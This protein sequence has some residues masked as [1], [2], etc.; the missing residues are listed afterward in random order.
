MNL[1][2]AASSHDEGR[3]CTEERE[4]RRRPVA[5][6]VCGVGDEWVACQHNHGQSTKRWRAAFGLVELS[7][8]IL[9]PR[10]HRGWVRRRAPRPFPQLK[11]EL[12][13]S[14]LKI[15]RETIERIALMCWGRSGNTRQ[16]KRRPDLVLGQIPQQT[17]HAVGNKAHAI[18]AVAEDKAGNFRRKLALICPDVEPAD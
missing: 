10:E 1:V 17:V 16:G 15:Y 4:S 11:V 13:A 12:Q 7:K 18:A 9:P 6:A 5:R 14:G 2:S 3:V 8:E